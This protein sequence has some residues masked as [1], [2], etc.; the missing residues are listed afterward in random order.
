MEDRQDARRKTQD[1]ISKIQD[2]I[3]LMLETFRYT[4]VSL[5][6]IR[7]FPSWGNALMLQP[8]PILDTEQ[9][10]SNEEHLI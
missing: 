8:I 9:K 4:C 7:S 10:I 3:T 5:I 6:A 1:T 2:T